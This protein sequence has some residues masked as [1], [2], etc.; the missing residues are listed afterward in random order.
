MTESEDF[1]RVIWPKHRNKKN[2]K[3]LKKLFNWMKLRRK[4][5]S[6]G[7]KIKRSVKIPDAECG[8]NAMVADYCN[9]TGLHI[10]P[11]VSLK[12]IRILEWHK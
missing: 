12:D 8:E 9:L 4:I 10:S 5:C 7:N 1:G 2:V 3:N 6:K 11:A